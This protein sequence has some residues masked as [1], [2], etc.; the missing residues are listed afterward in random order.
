MRIIMNTNFGDREYGPEQDKEASFRLVLATM[1]WIWTRFLPLAME[2]E[3]MKEAKVHS[4]TF[5]IPSFEPSGILLTIVF[6]KHGKKRHRHKAF[7][8]DIDQNGLAKLEVPKN[9]TPPTT[10][11][12]SDPMTPEQLIESIKATMEITV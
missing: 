11:I 1:T 6:T 4:L 3:Y 8:L 10:A 12:W 5:S 9:P 2:L 7:K